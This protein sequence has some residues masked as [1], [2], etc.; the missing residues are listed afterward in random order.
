MHSYYPASSELSCLLTKTPRS[1]QTYIYQIHKTLYFWSFNHIHPSVI[2]VS[3]VN[4]NRF[5]HES[6][7]KNNNKNNEISAPEE[8]LS[9]YWPTKTFCVANWIH[10]TDSAQIKTEFGQE[11]RKFLICLKK[12]S[13]SCSLTDWCYSQCCN[14]LGTNSFIKKTWILTK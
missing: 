5:R 14:K 4:F 7:W 6:V 10:R 1:T 8:V 2:V 9:K 12:L 13:S 11:L 3:N